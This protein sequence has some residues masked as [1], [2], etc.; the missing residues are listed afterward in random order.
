MGYAT[1]KSG[2]IRKQAV[3]NDD[4]DKVA[5]FD[6]KDKVVCEIATG[7]ADDA[8]EPEGVD[9]ADAPNAI[10]ITSITSSDPENMVITNQGGTPIDLQDYSVVDNVGKSKESNR[11]ALT[12][13]KLNPGPFAAAGKEHDFLVL[14]GPVGRFRL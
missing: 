1:T 2:S 5:L 11:F 9:E 10:S 6:T 4:G 7:A 14:A 13:G 3:L 12:K 8:T